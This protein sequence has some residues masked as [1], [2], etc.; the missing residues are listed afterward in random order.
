MATRARFWIVEIDLDFFVEIFGVDLQL[1]LFEWR[2][3]DPGGE[4]E[5]GGHH[6]AVVIIG[7]LTNEINPARRSKVVSACT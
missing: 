4:I 6:K 1:A 3:A 7:V 2:D 5:R